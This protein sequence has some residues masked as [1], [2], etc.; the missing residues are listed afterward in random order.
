MLKLNGRTED[1]FRSFNLYL[2]L[3]YKEIETNDELL[4]AEILD[5][6][7]KLPRSNEIK[8][9]MLDDIFV[10]IQ[11]Y[12]IS[13]LP[14]PGIL[15]GEVEEKI[16]EKEIEA[17][18]ESSK[19]QIDKVRFDAYE[20][21]VAA[22]SEKWYSYWMKFHNI[23]NKIILILA[24]L[25]IIAYALPMFIPGTKETINITIINWI[26]GLPSIVI[27]A[28]TFILTYFR[29]KTYEEYYLRTRK[30]IYKKFGIV[31]QNE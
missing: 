13:S 16:V 12:G 5:V 30:K 29:P 17:I 6:V 31:I 19:V 9:K 23:K 14:K 26:L 18:K 15:V 28:T 20:E 22:Q 2:N 7:E 21:I 11:Q 3:R 8:E 10:E 27:L 24:L 25:V 1:D 4:L